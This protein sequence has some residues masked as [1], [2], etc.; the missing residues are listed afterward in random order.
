MPS[1]S[2]MEPQARRHSRWLIVASFGGIAFTLVQLIV[3]SQAGM[4]PIPGRD[5]LIWD[6]VGDAIWTGAPIYYRAP[7]PTDSFWYTPPIA[8]LFGLVSWLPVVAQHWL[9]TLVRILSLRVIGGSWIGAGVACWFPLVAFD[10]GG[11]NFNLV[12]VAAIVAAVDRRPSLAVLAALAKFGPALAIDSRDLRRA[13]LVGAA[14]LALSLPWA[15]LWPQYAT[16]M[17]S[18]IGSPLGPQI[19]VPYWLRLGAAAALL[20]AIRRPWARALAA[21]LAVPAFYWGSLVLLLA[22]FTVAIRGEIPARA[23]RPATVPEAAT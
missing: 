8:V 15:Y 4:F 9:F 17:I 6:R 21:I 12:I 11:G 5:E 3:G 22:P 2:A 20:L 16:H 13:V 19:P 14:M 23:A 10:L 1:S 18:N 7:D